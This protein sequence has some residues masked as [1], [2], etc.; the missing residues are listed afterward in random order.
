MSAAAAA[1]L[2]R[3]IAN[4]PLEAQLRAKVERLR[5][6]A[7]SFGELEA[8]GVRLGL[9]QGTAE[10]RL[11]A[12][13]L[14]LFAA[15]HGLIVEGV[16][17]GERQPT[18]T[19][20]R[21]LLGGRL[22]L[23]SLAALHGFELMVVDSGAAEDVKPQPR[24]IARKIAHGTRNARSGPAMST[25]QAHA[26][27]RAGME[28]GDALGG[29]ALACAGIGV[30]SAQSAAL[31]LAC[32]HEVDLAELNDAGP[33]IAASLREHRL[34]VLGDIR[35]RHGHLDDPVELLAAVG[36]FEVAM[37]AGVMLVASSRRRLIIV[38]GL[39]ALAALAVASSIAP[40]VAD[41]CVAARSSSASAS[42]ERAISLAAI[43][44]LAAGAVESLDGTGAALAW[45]S[46]RC[47]AALLATPAHEGEEAN[48]DVA[49]ATSTARRV[50]SMRRARA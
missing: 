21:S 29:D 24:L 43:P 20:I 12:P 1:G 15:D 14:A 48:V 36:G 5:S 50:S 13:R 49:S 26:A 7:G 18:A 39:P 44:S 9:I 10:P 8:L 28:I 45:P 11:Q 17:A 16:V 42:V 6:T 47:A 27:M 38:D 46:L 23:L 35:A 3:P 41:Y 40:A 37:M 31:V 2:I 30:G 25:E 32:M 22:P 19:T 4:A 33:K 34:R